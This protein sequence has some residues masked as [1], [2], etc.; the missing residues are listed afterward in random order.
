MILISG[1]SF[2][3]D[4]GDN[5]WPTE[6]SQK[7]SMPILHFAHSGGSWWATRRKLL[8]AK[9]NGELDNIKIV[10]FCHTEGTRIPNVDDIPIGGWI[11]ENTT[12]L[13]PAVHKASKLYYEYLHDPAFALWSQQAWINECPSFFPKDTLIIHIHSFPYTY[14][15]IKI[16]NGVEFFPPL[17]ALSQ[18]EF[19]TNELAFAFI[20]NGDSRKNHLSLENNIELSCQLYNLINSNQTQG[21][22]EA[23]LS[24]FKINEVVFKQNCFGNGDIIYN[25]KVI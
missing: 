15:K 20:S 3:A 1:D 21:R 24:R 2:C 13:S 11:V 16:H 12:W 18:A 10:I 22:W 8:E 25:G 7:L 5:T 14:F 9:N 17:F 23:D 6:L 4:L 19:E